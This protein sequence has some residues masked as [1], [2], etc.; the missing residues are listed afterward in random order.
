LHVCRPSWRP[1]A[2]RSKAR[3]PLARFGGAEPHVSIRAKKALH[4]GGVERVRGWLRLRGSLGRSENVIRH[5][6][7]YEHGLSSVSRRVA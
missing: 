3:E 4:C 5:P 2:V 7:P 6:R 1:Q